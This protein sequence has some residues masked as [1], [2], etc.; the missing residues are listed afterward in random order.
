VLALAPAAAAQPQFEDLRRFAFPFVDDPRL[1]RSIAA[2]DVDRDGDVDLF[3]GGRPYLA[4]PG[5]QDRLFLNDGRGQFTDATAARLPAESSFGHACA[6]A[7]VDGDGDLDLYVGNSKTGGNVQ[8]QDFLWLN[9]GTGRFS[10]VTTA[11][12]PADDDFTEALAAGDVDGDGDVDVVLGNQVGQKLY[13][14]DGTGRFAAA[15][16]GA[17]PSYDAVPNAVQLGDVDRDGDLDVLM[18]FMGG[19][20]TARLYANDGTGRFTDVTAT[21]LA[22]VGE[23]HDG[24]LVDLDRDGD[25]DALTVTPGVQ[26]DRFW[27]N[28]GTGT[29]TDATPAVLA[30]RRDARV[31]VHDVDRDGDADVLLTTPVSQAA[32]LDLLRN[33]GAGNLAVVPGAVA[34]TPLLELAPEVYAFFD[35]DGD[36]DG[37]LVAS[38]R[39]TFVLGAAHERLWRNDGAGRFLDEA[40]PQLGTGM[41]GVALGDPDGDGDLD[42]L[43]LG[44]APRLHRNDGGNRFPEVAGALPALAG[45]ASAAEFADLDRDG[46]QDVV[47]ACD[48]DTVGA[49]N[50]LWRNDGN[51]RFTDLTTTHLPAVADRTWSVAVG[52]VDGDGDLDVA[53]GNY[54]TVPV[55]PGNRLLLNQGGLLFLEATTSHMPQGFDDGLLVGFGDADGDGDLD[56]VQGASPTGKLARNDGTG[57]FLAP[58]N[59]GMPADVASC[60]GVADLNGDGRVEVVLGFFSRTVSDAVCVNT[61][62]GSFN[63]TPLPPGAGR[64][65]ALALG[66][67]DRDGD[68]DVVFAHEVR[69]RWLANDGRAGLTEVT[70]AWLRPRS[71]QALALGDLD[72]DGDPD[73]VATPAPT[74]A[75][76]WNLHRQH[77]TPDFADRGARYRLELHARPG[78]ARIGAF[79]VPIVGAAE[80][81]PPVALPPLGVLGVDPRALVVLP[82]VTVR[83]TM[84]PLDLA[85]PADPSLR[86]ASLVTQ[87]VWLDLDA[88]PP[89]LR[90]GWWLADRVR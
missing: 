31:V 89:E 44:P 90:L 26:G 88:V 80:A 13:R 34:A 40:A 3:V 74:S 10:D 8:A 28:D 68:T 85:L 63:V 1:A 51:L 73:L 83:G 84:V 19:G 38:G 6:L 42:V 2:G 20:S 59:A 4:P 60:Q 9:D 54:G 5:G 24:V 66:D 33:D 50:R 61:G 71:G 23:P 29:F 37:D 7:D 46:D 30:G 22:G 32:P 82:N 18:V 25:L 43:L 21:R 57:R 86:G 75:I 69:T 35:A 87:G 17:L 76:W 55:A 70:R 14:N 77:W 45:T 27:R 36:G 47:V 56:L 78:Y 12:L 72:A 11:R 58:A 62:A 41:R 65:Q 16:A 52:D 67:A 48:A 81:L 64:T 39:T 53:F 79:C 15:P 49:Q